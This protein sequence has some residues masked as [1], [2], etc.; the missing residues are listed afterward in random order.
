MLH[1]IAI[2]LIITNSMNFALAARQNPSAKAGI[3][4]QNEDAPPPYKIAPGQ[5][6]HI[7]SGTGFFVSNDS[8]I[9]NE[10]VVHECKSIRIRGA[11]EPAFATLVSVD[12][13]NDLALLKTSRSPIMAAPL[14]GDLPIEVGE[15]VS[16]MGYP[17]EHGMKGSYL[18]RKAK[19][20]KDS[21]VLDGAERIQFTDSVE[22]GNSGGPLLDSNGTVIGVIV[23]K[24]SF[25]L[26]GSDIK[27]TQPIKTSSVAITLDTLKYFLDKNRIS[28]RIDNTLYKFEDSY[29]EN[30]AK[31]YI[32][33]IQCVKDEDGSQ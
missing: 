5:I 20:T 11:V 28:Y 9:T 31:D 33:N 10:H 32:V 21:D 13:K 8:I 16:V 29:M 23:G 6:I 3:I 7:S 18:I 2:I 14:R 25:Y 4:Y 19:I 26:A 17:L 1:F 27:N 30:K 22:K 24:V 12:K 15:E